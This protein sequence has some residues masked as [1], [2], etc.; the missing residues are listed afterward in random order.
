MHAE[1]VGN[2]FLCRR[3]VLDNVLLQMRGSRLR[4]FPRLI[5]G[6]PLDKRELCHVAKP[7]PLYWLYAAMDLERGMN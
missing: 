4:I 2:L 1:S 3:D 6:L 7:M 5:E